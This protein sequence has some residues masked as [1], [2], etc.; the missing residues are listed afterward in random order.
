MKKAN[1]SL[2]DFM[3]KE[4][5][6]NHWLIFYRPARTVLRGYYP[7]KARAEAQA[8]W[9][10]R[11]PEALPKLLKDTSWMRL[12]AGKVGNQSQNSLAQ[13]L[14]SRDAG[15]SVRGQSGK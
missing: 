1:S 12:A 15:F 7:S 10:L 11:Q 8:R 13:K 2:R 14:P 9:L 5:F 4:V 3:F 6:E